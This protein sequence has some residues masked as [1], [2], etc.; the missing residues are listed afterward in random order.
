LINMNG[1]LYDPAVGRFISPDNFVQAPGNSQSYNRY[2]YCLNNPLKY[3]DISGNSWWSHFW[4]WAGENAGSII[5]TVYLVAAVATCFVNPVL[6][7]AMIGGYIGGVSSNGGQ[8]NAGAWN[9]NDPATYCGI[10]VGAAMGAAGGYWAVHPDAFTLNIGLSSKYAQAFVSVCEVTAGTGKGTDWQFNFNWSTAAG[11][12]GSINLNGSQPP[13]AKQVTENAIADARAKGRNGS[14]LDP[15]TIGHNLLWL[16]YPGG[17]NPR[18]YS[19]DYTYSYVPEN[20]AEYPAIGHDRRYDK[21][22]ISGLNGLLTDQRA[23]GADMRYVLENMAITYSPTSYYSLTERVDAL[24]LGTGL[25]LMSLPKTLLQLAKPN[26]AL[27]MLGWYN[28]CNKGIT[29]IPSN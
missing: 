15:S 5:T 19:G 9:W 4:G 3:T 20:A 23:C 8:L 13:T 12:S 14:D 11:G 28:Y 7:G 1:R 16:S 25:G 22:G 2:S 27:E 21:L 18:T 24:I 29:N 17:N 26:G 6:G 10:F